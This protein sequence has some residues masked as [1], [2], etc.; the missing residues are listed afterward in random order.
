MGAKSECME[1]SCE[2]CSIFRVEVIYI[3]HITRQNKI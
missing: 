3:I 2:C 1:A